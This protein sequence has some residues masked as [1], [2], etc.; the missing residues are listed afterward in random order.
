MQPTMNMDTSSKTL[1]IQSSLKVKEIEDIIY[2]DYHCCEKTWSSLPTSPYTTTVAEGIIVRIMSRV[3]LYSCKRID[4]AKFQVTFESDF[5][6]DYGSGY[7]I[8]DSSDIKTSPIPIFEKTHTVSIDLNRVMCCDC[9][10]FENVGIFC[11]HMV[12][13]AQFVAEACKTKF[14]GFT[15]RDIA[16]RWTS[17]YMHLAYKI[18]TP[19]EIQKAYDIL[20]KND[21]KGPILHQS[22]PQIVPIE[23]KTPKLPAIQRLKNYD[24]IDVSID[25]NEPFDG[26]GTTFI[27]P[28]GCHRD[29]ESLFSDAINDSELP[30]TVTHNARSA[31]KGTLDDVLRMADDIGEEGVKQ[32]EIK[33]QEFKS[34]CNNKRSEKQQEK[35]HQNPNGKRKTRNVPMTS[36]KYTSNV[37]RVLNTHHM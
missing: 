35:E 7:D 5:K 10:F 31:L 15:H 22:I 29:L 11:V 28:I 2:Q 34:W 26:M 33:L 17:A 23:E 19:N 3:S 18:T 27:E 37:K 24:L 30:V 14:N 21:I 12:R 36:D 32:L 4:L 1:N 8:D 16:V 20:T 13:V 9:Y 6:K 25:Q